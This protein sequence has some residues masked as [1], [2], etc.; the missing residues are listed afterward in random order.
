MR[1]HIVQ[2]FEMNVKCKIFFKINM[3]QERERFMKRLLDGMRKYIIF[4]TFETKP[5]KISIA[6]KII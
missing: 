5:E 4:E 3:D 6:Q 2:K 1:T